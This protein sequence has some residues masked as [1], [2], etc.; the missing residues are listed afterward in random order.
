VE[1]FVGL[2]SG[3]SADGIDAALLRISSPTAQP[4]GAEPGA[5]SALTMEVEASL[6]RAYPAAMRSAVLALFQPGDNEIDRLG[7]LD[8]ALGEAFAETALSLLARQGLA[9]ADVRAIGSHGQTVRHRPG[10]GEPGRLGFTL[11]IGD[12]HTIAE[13]TGIT[14]VADFRRRDVAAGGEGAP[15]VPA[16][17]RACFAVAGERR[18]VLNLGGIAN[19]TLLDGEQL[20]AGFDTGPANALLDHWAERHLGTPCDRGG[21]WAAQGRVIPEL[22]DQ[23]LSDPYF[24]RRGPRSTGREHFNSQW[25]YQWAPL[26]DTHAAVDV[27]ATLAEL[28]AKSIA[29]ALAA[30]TFNPHTVLVCGGGVHNADL[31]ERLRANLA[32]GP[33][34][35]SCAEAGMDPDA[36]EAAAFAWLAYR[37]LSGQSGNAPQ[38]TGA[39]GE[40]ILGAICHAG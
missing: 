11:Q 30:A 34:V 26:L 32:W 27:Q 12:P 8:R 16:F 36:L 14:T 35:C 40:R 18:A 13:R 15:L 23:M 24:Q 1:R 19:L 37:C 29:Q 6:T 39:A 22:L 3:T 31:L 25:L 5:S 33:R 28:S 10:R 9:P 21:A 38:V 7:E 20:L 4:A 2:I 17:H